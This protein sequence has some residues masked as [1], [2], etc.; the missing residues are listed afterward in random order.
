[1]NIEID[2]R[3][4][5]G[6]SKLVRRAEIEIEQPASAS[7]DDLVRRAV[8]EVTRELRTLIPEDRK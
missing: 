6:S 3:V 7:K 5:P 1:M 2:I 4:Q 8:Y